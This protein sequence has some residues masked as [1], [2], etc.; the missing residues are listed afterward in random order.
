M[1]LLVDGY[2]CFWAGVT[3][4]VRSKFIE[5]FDSDDSFLSNWKDEKM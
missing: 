4:F 2:V 5:L 3:N 1:L